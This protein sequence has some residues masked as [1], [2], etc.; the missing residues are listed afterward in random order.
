MVVY[1]WSKIPFTLFCTTKRHMIIKKIEIIN[2]KNIETAELEFSE[3][4]NCVVGDNGQGKTNLLDAIYYLSLTKSSLGTPDSIVKG[5]THDFFMVTASY[6]N[7]ELTKNETIHCSYK[8]GGGKIVKRNGKE[9]PRLS[10]H[11]GLIP[12]VIASP[13]DNYLISDA[14]ETRRKHINAL[15]AQLDK[16][17][18]NVVVKYN[19]LLANRNK[20]LKMPTESADEIIEII[21][22]QLV[23]LAQQIHSIRQTN[24]EKLLPLMQ[25]IYEKISE[26][27]EKIK[28]EYQSELNKTSLEILLKEN[29]AKDKI[30]GHTSVGVHRDDMKLIIDGHSVKRYGSQGQQKSLTLALKLAQAKLIYTEKNVKP[31]LLLDD[32]CD[33]L[34]PQ[35]V[36]ALINVVCD[37]DFGQIFLSDSNA[38][39]I[40]EIIKQIG[41]DY[42][43]FTAEKGCFVHNEINK[44]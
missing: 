27:K 41:S 17:Y 4:L 42:K 12:V 15:L 8:S 28:I 16:N 1:L 13:N 44:K 30:L 23:P 36:N 43:I 25:E 19:A 38:K 20:L 29:L 2:F 26:G 3:K 6:Q 9:Y 22:M 7:N 31:I 11:I 5:G 24:I 33:K 32:L 40:K 18:L 35:R 10:E 37:D 39:R 34:D 14:A 21:D